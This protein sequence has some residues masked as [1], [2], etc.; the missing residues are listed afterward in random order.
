LPE[1][2]L[3]VLEKIV[4]ETIILDPGVYPTNFFPG[5]FPAGP[6]ARVLQ[7]QNF[8]AEPADSRP[9]MDFLKEK[10]FRGEAPR[11][12]FAVLSPECINRAQYID[13]NL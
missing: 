1:A 11:K 6:V 12:K 7:G 5:H 9:L 13:T 4:V 8:A 3:N 2:L 10:S